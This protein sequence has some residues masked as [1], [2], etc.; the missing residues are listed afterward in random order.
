MFL[1][2]LHSHFADTCGTLVSHGWQ[3]DNN[4]SFP[5]MIEVRHG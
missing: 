5:R 1:P 3:R 2:G 4:K